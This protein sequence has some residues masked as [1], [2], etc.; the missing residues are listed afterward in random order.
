MCIIFEECLRNTD[1]FNEIIS[2]RP[3]FLYSLYHNIDIDGALQMTD[4]LFHLPTFSG[5]GGGTGW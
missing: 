1:I 4:S 3:P 2:K 5:M